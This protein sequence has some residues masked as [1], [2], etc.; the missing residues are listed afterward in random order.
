MKERLKNLPRYKI[1]GKVTGVKGPLIE[2]AL[3]KVCLGDFCTIDGKVEAEVVGFKDGRTLLM[4]YSDTTGI[5]VGSQIEPK[6]GSVKV[7]VS[8]ELLG[9]VVDPFGNPLNRDKI[10]Y[11]DFTYLQGESINPLKRDRIREPLDLGIRSINALLTVGKGQRIGIFS[12]AGVGKSTLM[13]MIAR[14]TSAD[15]NVIVLVG[16]RGREVREFIEDNLGREGL[17]KSVVVVATS[18]QPPLAKIRAVLTGCAIAEYFSSQNNDVLLLLDS[19]TRLAMAQREIGL[20]VGEPPTTKGYVPSVFSLL[21]KV[22]ERAGNFTGQGSITG[23]YTVLVEGDEI[24]L[25][26][27]ADAAVGFLDGHIVLSRA[28][29][30][31]RIFPA[32]DILKSISRLTPQLVSE[33]VLKWQSFF[34]DLEATYRE[35]QDMVNLGLYKKGTNPKID[36]AIAVHDKME[37]FMKQ[38]IEERVSFEESLSSLKSLIKYISN[39][40][41]KYG[42]QWTDV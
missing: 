2:S 23:I 39:E 3:P 30:N 27:V 21:S 12:G 29:A 37:E 19:L 34:I 41:G 32:I 11:T 35:S 1:V 36:L 20:T 24:A 7:G 14:Y 28:L 26:P 38:R 13:G 6:P 31:R 22:I 9:T 40:G 5:S 25:D 18:D 10:T 4:A 33:E 15:V 8:R 42:Y 16:E 17:K